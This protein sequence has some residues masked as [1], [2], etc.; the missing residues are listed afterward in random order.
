MESLDL[1][2]HI[3]LR[4]QADTSAKDILHGATLLGEGVDDGGA[5]GN[6]RGLE[7]VAEDREDRVEWSIFRH[8]FR[9]VGYTGHE[10]GKDREV[11]DQGR[12]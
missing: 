6:K 8:V 7:H 5:R 2:H 10:F 11:N 4:R 1:Q 3:I 9:L 12:G